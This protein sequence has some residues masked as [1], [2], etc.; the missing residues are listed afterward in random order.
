MA[1][2]KQKA[3]IIFEDDDLLVVNKPPFLLSI[4]DRWKKEKPNVLDQMRAHCQAPFTVHRLDKE[5]SGILIL[6]KNADAHKNLSQQFEKRTVDKKYLALVEDASL[7]E[8]GSISG[9]IA[10]HPVK[11][12]RMII[13]NKGKISLTEYRTLEKFNHFTLAEATIK[14]GRMHQIR[15]HFQSIG[16]PLAID[17]VYGNRDQISFTDIKKSKKNLGKSNEPPR[18]LM[19]RITLHAWKL[20]LTHPTT[21]KIINFTAPL[22]KDFRALL[23]QLRKWQQ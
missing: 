3:S 10:P 22:P 13:S 17:S 4:P 16:Y 20:Q 5:T 12:G 15:V 9:S 8:Q 11:K 21:K 19:S 14:T 1:T 18:P 6:A 7:P 2:K 23:N